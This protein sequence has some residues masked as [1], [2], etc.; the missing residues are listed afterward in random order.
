MRVELLLALR[1]V[2]CKSFDDVVAPESVRVV[3]VDDQRVVI[4]TPVEGV[5]VLAGPRRELKPAIRIVVRSNQRA[6]AGEVIVYKR[7]V[8]VPEDHERDRDPLLLR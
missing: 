5:D 1:I 8:D 4:A 2:G 6:G 7:G 3:Q